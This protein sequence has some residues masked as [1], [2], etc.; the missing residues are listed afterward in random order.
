[1]A[2]IWSKLGYGT[3][4]Y[5]ISLSDK[6]RLD[7]PSK[8]IYCAREVNWKWNAYNLHL[9]FSI[10]PIISY[11]MFL[12]TAAVIQNSFFSSRQC[13]KNPIFPCIHTHEHTNSDTKRECSP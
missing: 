2:G 9:Q 4:E 5:E 13:K 1:M 10:W 7:F 11:S 3:P 12:L 6:E 8:C